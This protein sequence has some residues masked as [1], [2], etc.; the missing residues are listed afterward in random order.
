MLEVLDKGR[1][2]PEEDRD[3]LTEPYVSTRVKGTGLGL[4]I[5]AKVMEDHKG[6]ISF[7]DRA[8]GGACV[9]LV[10]PLGDHGELDPG[11]DPQTSGAPI[12]V[13]AYGT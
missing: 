10:F 5:V 1:G 9:R 13:Q 7:E 4:A 12:D 2:L 3:R 8:E 6:T 11:S